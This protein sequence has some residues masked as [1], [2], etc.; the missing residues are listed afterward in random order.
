MKIGS[1]GTFGEICGISEY[2]KSLVNGL[3]ARGHEVKVVAN[4]SFSTLEPDPSYVQRLFHAPFLTHK[5][6]ADVMGMVEYLKD[7]DVIHVHFELNLYHPSWFIDFISAFSFLNKPPKI[8][9]TM[10]SIGMWP[11]MPIQL[12][13]HFCSHEPMIQLPNQT[14]IPMSVKFFSDIEPQVD[15]DSI[16]SFGLGRNDD[17]LVKD[18]IKD[19]PYKFGTTYGH[20]KWLSLSELVTKIKSSWIVSLVYPEVG[21]QVSSSAV[22]LAM[23][24]DRPIIC[25][26]TNWFKHVSTEYANLYV[27]D[28]YDP[29][30][31]NRDDVV[32]QIK[33]TVQYL[34]NKENR[35]EVVG[36]I[37]LMKDRIIETGRDYDSVVD[38]YIKV[39]E[40][41]LK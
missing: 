5:T 3:K 17:Q 11:S 20:I 24:C 10:H 27:V 41:V 2:Q 7:C 28:P 13:D 1:V 30:K 15:F 26:N 37:K 21:I 4:Y 31:N 22:T 23:G 40:D 38:K 9:F 33:E 14:V 39:Y 34:M 8:V 29:S 16:I 18:A 36:N 12:V 25:T 19:T 35:K 32:K 6:T